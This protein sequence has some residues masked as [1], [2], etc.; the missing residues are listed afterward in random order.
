MSGHVSGHALVVDSPIALD[1]VLLAQ[2][3]EEIIAADQLE[4]NLDWNP[5]FYE[6]RRFCFL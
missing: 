3:L 2:E 6:V 4:R 5:R 1:P